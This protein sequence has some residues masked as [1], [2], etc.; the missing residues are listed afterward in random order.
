MKYRI[1]K[2]MNT[3][4]LLAFS[5]C[6]GMPGDAMSDQSALPP[7]GGHTAF[8]TIETTK[9]SQN[10]ADQTMEFV[11]R[12]F[13]LGRDPFSSE[14]E[15]YFFYSNS[16]IREVYS[17]LIT[18]LVERP[19]ISMLTG[20][21]GVGKTIL[22]RR[23]CNELRTVGH[24]VISR[25]RA[26]LVYQDLVKTIAKE[27]GIV[28]CP[29][30]DRPE[31]LRRF[32]WDLAQPRASPP[33]ILV[34]DDAEGLG[35]DVITAM[36]D[37]LPRG[38]AEG[39]SLR[40]LLS[41][42]PNLATRLD[43]P[44]F[45][46]LRARLAVH[47]HLERLDDGQAAGY[48]FHRLR[49]AGYRG[50][51]LCT[52]AAINSIVEHS[53]GL[54][55]QINLLCTQSLMS[56][57]RARR[58]VITSEVVEEAIGEL[59]SRSPGPVQPKD[60]P[61]RAGG[62]RTITAA[63]MAAG[64]IAITASVLIASFPAR[65]SSPDD[66]QAAS[67]LVEA[68][69]PQREFAAASSA[70]PGNNAGPAPVLVAKQSVV[71]V[72][73]P[74]EAA[75]TEQSVQWGTVNAETVPAETSVD[76]ATN[77]DLHADP[78]D[79]N[80]PQTATA[81]LPEEEHDE[82]A[83]RARIATADDD[84][85][86]LQS[87]ADAAASSEARAAIAELVSVSRITA[88][89]IGDPSVD[90]APETNRQ[91][92]LEPDR[93]EA[94]RKVDQVKTTSEGSERDPL[95][96]GGPEDTRGSYDS[97]PRPEAEIPDADFVTKTAVP[98]ADSAEDSPAVPFR[99]ASPSGDADA[100]VSRAVRKTADPGQPKAEQAVS[101]QPQSSATGDSGD[102]T[103]PRANDKSSPMPAATPAPRLNV[104]RMSDEMMRVL[105][106][107]GADLVALGDIS[108]ARLVYERAASGGSA[109]AMTELGKTYD[110]AYLERSNVRGIRPDLATAANWY[111]KAVALGD[112]E[113]VSL[114]EHLP[115]STR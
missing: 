34:I 1:A 7:V 61:R 79:G 55:R 64:I 114:S 10:A 88:D 24:I 58:S 41:G 106:K 12:F 67:T 32:H 52:S 46:R 17:R 71:H 40:I 91:L 89:Q 13:S 15:Q 63:S 98:N 68:A 26:G 59:L 18:A 8:S 23:L 14:P 42:R 100:S 30:E 92:T 29:A 111:R 102:P 101:Q 80:V 25:Y 54:P 33:P 45:A 11:L 2:K 39:S 110:P 69:P 103:P 35:G 48:V 3:S 85:S 70:G 4:K 65:E 74:G 87:S 53:A 82:A 49:R 57:A 78:P 113:A 99:D 86:G 104:A 6:S 20:E 36:G 16:A 72:E 27:M 37:L 62:P 90:N 47:C 96:A 77:W 43:L 109:K 38:G 94:G 84:T 73:L 112:A 9:Q 60:K 97:A 75:K 31:W 76:P 81:S 22:I 28:I 83:S 105:M 5:L 95:K 21:G 108:A 107:R 51:D 19:G 93:S 50:T 115:T 44:V 56:A 66:D